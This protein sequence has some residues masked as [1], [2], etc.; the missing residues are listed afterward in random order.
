MNQTQN[1]IGK[2]VTYFVGNYLMSGVISEARENNGR[3]MITV[4]DES[5]PLVKRGSS[6]YL[7]QNW[8]QFL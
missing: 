5:G 4:Q 8:V 3:T 1:L 2:Q 7:D 6:G